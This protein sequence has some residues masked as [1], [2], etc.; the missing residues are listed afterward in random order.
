MLE[1]KLLQVVFINYF[2][3]NSGGISEEFRVKRY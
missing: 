1:N 3:I 2:R